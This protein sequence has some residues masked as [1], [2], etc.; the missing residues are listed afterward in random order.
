MGSTDGTTDWL[1]RTGYPVV[2]APTNVDCGGAWRMLYDYAT[3]ADVVVTLDN[4]M[5]SERPWADEVLAVLADD[6]GIGAV[7]LR[8]NPKRRYAGSARVRPTVEVHGVPVVTVSKVF[9]AV[10][11]RGEVFRQVIPGT[12]KAYPDV[13]VSKRIRQAGWTLARMYPGPC[14]H[15]QDYEEDVAFP[16]Y[17]RACMD[18]GRHGAWDHARRATRAKEWRARHEA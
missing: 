16:E 11:Y 17:Y 10:A 1:W 14:T 15:L 3:D 2:Y 4:D 9:S 5:I 12:V 7:S 13:E 18:R 6:T 8:D